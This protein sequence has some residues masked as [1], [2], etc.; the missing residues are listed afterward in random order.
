MSILHLNHVRGELEK[1]VFQHVDTSDLK[2]LSVQEKENN[3]LSRSLTLFTLKSLTGLKY[4]D[5]KD[6]E[7]DGYGDNGID[8][9]YFD[10]KNNYFYII[11][12]KWIKSANGGPEKSEIL[13]LL[14]GIKD[15]L[16][17]NFDSFNEKIKSKR[18]LIK[19]AFLN[20]SI[21]IKVLLTFTGIKISDECYRTI[22]ECFDD[23]NDANDVIFFE[24]F[25]IRDCHRALTLGIEGNPI[26]VDFDLHQWGKHDD[27]VKSI[28]GQLNCLFLAEVFDQ[29]KARL[30]SQNIRGFMG[31][32]EINIQ[33]VNSITKD[34]E[35]FF[36]LNNGITILA[37]KI[38]K[39]AFGGSDRVTGRFSCEDITIVNG[40]QT[41]GSIYEAF[42]RNK[43]QVAKA[44][45]FIRIV[46]LE[47]CPEDFDKKVTVATNTQNRI[48]KKD[49]VSLDINQQRLKKECL[50]DGINYHYKRD[51]VPTNPNDK[52][53]Y[54]EEATIA[55]SCLYYDI[56]LAILAKREISTLW[57]DTKNPPYKHLFNDDLSAQKLVKTIVLFRLIEKQ[58]KEGMWG[59]AEF[60]TLIQ[61]HGNYIIAHLVFQ[62]LN[63]DIINN[64]NIKIDISIEQSLKELTE[65]YRKRVIDKFRSLF[66]F[67]FPPTLFKNG[68]MVNILRDEIF[69]E[70]GKIRPGKTLPLFGKD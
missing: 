61:I 65:K 42:K 57:T 51:D 30:F 17:F 58:I 50:L 3:L 22:K 19:D 54:L 40:A 31:E 9:V 55:L 24:P 52:N 6:S 68:Q 21:K 18:E 62:D 15:I 23:L 26:N 64:P 48:E 53:F 46:S 16:S 34:P 44:T 39:S 32:S 36:Y 59:Q 10:K 2:K 43:D 12:S 56:E 60:D 14:Q 67:K 33:I 38:T 69:K 7:T 4:E 27:P 45:V 1:N 29:N 66:K 35:N 11:Q 41:V 13:K 47:N 28:Y 25:N 63:K 49:F 5:L 8:G 37:K 20:S 70:E